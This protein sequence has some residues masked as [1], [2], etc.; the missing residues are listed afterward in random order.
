MTDKIKILIVEDNQNDAELMQY[1]LKKAGLSFISEIVQTSEAFEDALFHFMPDIILS[2]FALP[3]FDGITAFHIKQKKSPDI[4]FIIVSGTLGEER[5]VELIKNGVTDYILKEK[6]FT[7][8]TKVIRA[9]KE[10]EEK[11]EKRTADEKMKAQYEKLLEIAFLQSHQ[12]R[13]PI[14]NVIGL[15]NLFNF[16]T[17]S[18]PINIKV[19]KNLKK[20]ILVF[21]NIIREI[22]KKTN[23]IEKI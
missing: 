3:S 8:G 16:D 12:V 20:A 4:P 14:T 6:L 18:D 9:L 15:I 17:P 19:I 10:A 5:A 2:D 21:D 7:S 23:E 11:K 13:A 1:Q 22:V